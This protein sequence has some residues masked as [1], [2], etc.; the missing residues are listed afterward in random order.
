MVFACSAALT[1]VQIFNEET[2]KRNK[3]SFVSILEIAEWPTLREMGTT[4]NL[5]DISIFLPVHMMGGKDRWSDHIFYRLIVELR[6][7]LSYI[8]ASS[9][10]R[11]VLGGFYSGSDS[12]AANDSSSLWNESE[13]VMKLIILVVWETVFFLH[14][15]GFE[16]RDRKVQKRVSASYISEMPFPLA[17]QSEFHTQ[18]AIIYATG[19]HSFA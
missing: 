16:L 4:E 18:K 8:N 14:C 19:L 10:L 1:L 9:Y 17:A 13:E 7:V 11:L 6:C 2:D 3:K 12:L 15:L 5:L